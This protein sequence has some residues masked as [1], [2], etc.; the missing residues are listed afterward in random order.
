MELKKT[1]TCPV[2]GVEKQ[3]LNIHLRRI[4]K[5]LPEDAMKMFGFDCLTAPALRAKRTG[6]N[7]SFFG[8]HHSVESKDKMIL[9][10]DGKH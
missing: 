5:I 9:K 10:R 7:N 3:F 1:L 2:C 6:R 4:H 8:K